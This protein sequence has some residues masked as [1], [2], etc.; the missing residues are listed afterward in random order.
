MSRRVCGVSG[1]GTGGCKYRGIVRGGGFRVFAMRFKEAGVQEEGLRRTA[2]QK[3]DGER[4]HRRGIR[5]LR[6]Q[7]FI[8]ADFF[9]GARDMLQACEDRM[10]SGIAQRVQHVP[11]VIGHGKSAMR[12]TEH[13]VLV[14][15]LAGEQRRTAGRA[16]GRGAERL[17]EENAL[18]GQLLNIGRGHRVAVRLK[19]AAGIVR[20]QI[21]DVGP[22]HGGAR[23]LCGERRGAD[24]G[25]AADELPAR[26][27]MVV[28][29]RSLLTPAAARTLCGGGDRRRRWPRHRWG[30]S[31]YRG[32]TSACD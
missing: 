2:V 28:A 17:P 18:R 23:G 22:G 31:R 30:M 5:I 9:G 3:L 6:P 13:A 26:I 24:Y 29:H 27:R 11:R 12:E 15:A 21:D 10:V 7:Q 14:G 16:G 8:E 25:G 19:V 1:S 32:P 20:M 4:R